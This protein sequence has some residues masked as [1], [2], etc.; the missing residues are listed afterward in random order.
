MKTITTQCETDQNWSN[1]IVRSLHGCDEREN[2][3]KCI[4]LRYNTCIYIGIIRNLSYKQWNV[5]GDFVK[6][7]FFFYKIDRGKS[8]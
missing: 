2:M 5:D 6:F 8:D 3:T 4:I 1:V 7:G